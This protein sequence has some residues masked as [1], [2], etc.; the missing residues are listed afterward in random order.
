MKAWKTKK[1]RIEGLQCLL[2]FGIGSSLLFYSLSQQRQIAIAWA[3][4]PYLFPL[5]ISI[6]LLLLAFSLMRETIRNAKAEEAEGELFSNTKIKSAQDKVLSNGK[7][8]TA[9]GELRFDGKA[10]EAEGELPSDAKAETTEGELPSDGKAETAEGELSSDAKA[11]MAEGELPSDAKAEMTGGEL[12]SDGK[13]ET[14]EGELPSNGKAETGLEETV[15]NS[16][17]ESSR[18]YPMKF[19]LSLVGIFLYYIAMPYLG[20]LIASVLFLAAM[21][22]L[23]GERRWQIVLL[24]SAGTALTLYGIFHELLHVLLP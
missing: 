17:A 1:Y 10:E 9:E 16:G 14:T 4:S 24:L 18:P 3:M 7:A 23:L 13:A 22:W 15:Q 2:F 6:F 8:E 19:W 12:S 20:F 21:L 5:L 11:E